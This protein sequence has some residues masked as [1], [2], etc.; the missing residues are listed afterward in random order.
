MRERNRN[1]VIGRSPQRERTLIAAALG[2]LTLLAWF[3][4]W[5]GAGMGMSALEM[6]RLTLFPHVRGDAMDGMEMDP[7]GVATVTAMWW[8]MMIA[9]MTPG[10]MP[11]AMLYARVL[12]NAQRGAS[13][14]VVVPTLFVAAG[15]LLAWLGFAIVAT[16]L[17]YALVGG[18]LLS[19]M[20]LWSQSA[21]LSAAVL[22]AAGLYQ[23]TP[24]KQSCLAHC[25]GPV[26]F[27]TRHF[28]P[29]YPGAIAIGLR[30]GA[31]CVGCCWALMVLLFVGGVMNVA[32]IAVLSLLVLAEKLAPAGAWLSRASG[33][34][35]IAW[36][37]A[38]LVR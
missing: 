17:Q 13:V 28:R 25:R 18:G 37:A 30:H 14:A 4:V 12:R 34:V 31:W 21:V 35:L 19:A 36:A 20:M 27:L 23:L 26:A 2:A 1:D 29:G 10:A 11:L 9:M 33:L 3:H 24:R 16:G 32:W 38:T 5:R 8:V 15:Y 7:V 6:T 22:A